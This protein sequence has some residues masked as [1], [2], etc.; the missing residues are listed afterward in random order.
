MASKPISESYK[1]CTIN[2]HNHGYTITGALIHEVDNRQRTVTSVITG[3]Q[4]LTPGPT[5]DSLT[6]MQAAKNWID[7]HG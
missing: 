1:G 3:E 7:A 6:W 2:A 4:I 5:S